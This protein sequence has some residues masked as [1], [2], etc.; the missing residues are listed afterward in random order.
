MKSLYSKYQSNKHLFVIPL[1]V[2]IVA[3]FFIPS[4]IQCEYE[5]NA[6]YVPFQVS[7]GF[8]NLLN[9]NVQTA[10]TASI[11]LI[12]FLCSL[13]FSFLSYKSLL[14]SIGTTPI[15]LYGVF[16]FISKMVFVASNSYVSR[17]FG[18]SEKAYSIFYLVISICVLA[19][20]LFLFSLPLI[21]KSKPHKLSKSERIA[22]L[23]QQVAELQSKLPSES[24]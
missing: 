3:L 16:G 7:G 12:V 10:L 21:A 24:D 8:L 6:L 23:E 22:D 14:F 20:S 15:S 5:E 17:S 1:I 11:V 4:G 13:V 9:V 2:L 18:S 19:Y